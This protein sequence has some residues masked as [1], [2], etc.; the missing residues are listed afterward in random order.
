MKTKVISL[1]FLCS[2]F[3]TQA[4][5][6]GK[7]TPLLQGYFKMVFAGDMSGA[8][9]LINNSSDDP[10]V[11][12]LK[13]RFED[14]FINQTSGLDLRDVG[15]PIVNQFLDLFQTY[16]RNALLQVEPIS[17]LDIE[18]K[19]NLNKILTAHDYS[20][21]EDEDLLLDNVESLIRNEG[22]FALSGR[23]PPLLELMV[24]KQ[25]DIKS[26]EIELSENTYQVE[27]NY[28]DDFISYGWSNF[29][30]FGMTSTGGWA[31]K[32]G[33][34][35]L[36][37]NYD[38]ESER[39]ELSFLKH[40]GRHFADFKLFPKLQASD[41]EYRAKL[42]EL[43]YAK[44]GQAG[45]L[46]HFRSSANKIPNAPHPLANWYLIEGLTKQLFDE[47]SPLEQKQWDQLNAD[48]IKNAA[49]RLYEEHEA[50]LVK[51]GSATTVGVI[52]I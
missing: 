19:E 45:L 11:G 17:I 31:E 50:K 10:A 49:K 14:R 24:W 52:S 46:A 38:L 36:C 37:A 29:A 47:K 44:E 1:F 26:H 34:Y 25:N 23:T 48:Q 15:S 41:L 43:I 42:T 9:A 32:E 5:A 22:Y 39:F 27:V 4:L 7:S 2:I 18:L 12:M 13:G 6:H 16:W 20:S 35:C 30:T 51:L 21:T 28:L 8:E 33:L 40:E 3:S